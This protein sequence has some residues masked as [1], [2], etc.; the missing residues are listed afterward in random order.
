MNPELLPEDYNKPVAYD[1]N[2]QPLYSHP[3]VSTKI[4]GSTTYSQVQ[5]KVIGDEIRLKHDKSK[6]LY[7][8]LNLSESEYVISAVKRHPIG[9]AIPMVIGAMLISFAF[10]FLFNFDLAAQAFQIDSNKVSFSALFFPTLLFTLLVVLATYV[11]YYIYT[12]NKFFL[13]SESVIQ[14]IQTSL[15]THLE[16]TV[17]LMNIEDASF[18][19]IGIMQLLFNYGSIRLS[20]EGEETTYRFAYVANPKAHIAMINNAM[21]AFRAENGS[22]LDA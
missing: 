13:T 6:Q 4:S 12:N 1:A 14:E 22:T 21:E 19:Q 17:S 5:E 7:P 11:Y 3:P 9:L 2:G 20:T 18:T 10:I 15:F 8:E 16:Q